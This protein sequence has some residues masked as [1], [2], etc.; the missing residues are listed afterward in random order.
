MIY[1]SGHQNEIDSLM[2][3]YDWKL[4]K[5]SSFATK[6]KVIDELSAALI[7]LGLTQKK[8]A[9]IICKERQKIVEDPS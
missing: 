3:R 2:A 5:A 6:T 1:Q 4:K 7:G 9:E 8:R